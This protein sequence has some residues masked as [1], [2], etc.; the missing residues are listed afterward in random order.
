[1]ERFVYMSITFNFLNS[2]EE[3]VL[4]TYDSDLKDLVKS[5]TAV[6]NNI[7]QEHSLI[8]FIGGAIEYN[9]LTYQVNLFNNKDMYD[10]M[11]NKK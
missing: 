8:G 11:I 7:I 6:L 9:G 10:F 5:K 2:Y 4:K 3:N 1:M